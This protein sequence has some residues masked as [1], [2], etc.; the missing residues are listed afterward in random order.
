MFRKFQLYFA[1]YQ[2]SKKT[3]ISTKRCFFTFAEK[4][5]FLIDWLFYLILV[6]MF[7]ILEPVLIF[8]PLY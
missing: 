7:F 2:S 6:L 3:Y 4:S 8:P 5:V 1:L